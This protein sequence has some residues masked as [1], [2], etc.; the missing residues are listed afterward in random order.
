L[1]DVHLQPAGVSDIVQKTEEMQ[2]HA[3]L[4]QSWEQTVLD[5]EL[6][7]VGLNKHADAATWCITVLKILL[8]PDMIRVTG[9]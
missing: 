6:R 3:D 8:Y 4:A 5:N 9:W 7:C 2:L 1:N